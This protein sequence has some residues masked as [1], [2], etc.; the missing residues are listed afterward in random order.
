MPCT[1]WTT[2]GR[3]DQAALRPKMPALD[4]CVHH[5]GF[6]LRIKVRSSLSQRHSRKGAGSRKCDDS[7]RSIPAGT[8]SAMDPG[9]MNG[10]MD[11][12]HLM[13]TISLTSTRQQRLCDP[14]RISRVE[15]CM[16]RRLMVTQ[17]SSAIVR[18][19]NATTKAKPL[20]RCSGTRLAAVQ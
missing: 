9:T 2:A 6:Q 19:G 13:A 14:P 4:E 7:I 12:R 8:S 17:R 16:M 10:T 11:Q 20:G 1:V 18:R 3:P 5:I 15:M